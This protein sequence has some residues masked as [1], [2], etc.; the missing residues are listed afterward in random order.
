MMN[1]TAS[2]IKTHALALPSEARSELIAA[3]QQSL[4]TDLPPGQRMTPA[5]WEAEILRRSDELHA[6]KA[7]FMS[8][9][10][11]IEQG[12]SLIAKLRKS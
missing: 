2:D 1:L 3:L 12:E 6:G 11:S 8:A 4:E 10:E 9:D 5:E 7:E